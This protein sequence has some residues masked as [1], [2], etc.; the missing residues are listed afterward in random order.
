MD[1]ELAISVDL[2]EAVRIINQKS[3]F[4]MY[5]EHHGFYALV[6][7]CK[8]VIVLITW[9]GCLKISCELPHLLLF[10]NF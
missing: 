9:M 1:K 10:V 8:D 6:R 4:I 5:H 2:S 3:L 7:G